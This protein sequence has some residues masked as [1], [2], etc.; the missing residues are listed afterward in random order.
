DIWGPE[1]A[2][3]IAETGG[4]ILL[5]LNGSPYRQRVADER[6]NVIV[7]RVKDT[8]LPLL[9]ANQVGGQD[10]LVFD[11]ASLGLNTDCSL[12]F[13]LP[14]Y[15]ECVVTTHWRREA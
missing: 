7:P 12:A 3:C 11:G 15:K 10:E 8:G 6:L 4:E 1:S 14:A 2:E 5:V 9:Y 13:Q